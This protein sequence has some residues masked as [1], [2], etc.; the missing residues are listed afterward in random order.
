MR[1]SILVVCMCLLGTALAQAATPPPVVSAPPPM[2]QSPA[3]SESAA[4][5]VECGLVPPDFRAPLR[6]FSPEYYA[7]QKPSCLADRMAFYKV[8]GVSMAIIDENRIAWARGYGRLEAGTDRMV[9]TRSVFEA[10]SATKILTTVVALRLAEKGVVDLDRDVNAYLRQWKVP[11]SPLTASQ[12]VTLRLLLTHRAGINRPA[13]GLPYDST[14]PAT[15]AQV[16]AG[17]APALN[18]GATI[19]HEPGTIHQYSNIGFLVIQAVL[20]DASGKPFEELARSLVFEPLGLGASTLTHPL[21]QDWENR[22]GVPHDENGT[23][24]RRQQM[25]GAVAHGGLVTSPSDLARLAIEIGLAC[26]GRSTRLLSKKSAAMMVAKVADIDPRQFG[27]PLGQGLGVMLLGEGKT[28]HFLHPGGNDPGANCWV[29][30]CPSTGQGAVIMTNA[31]AGE[32]LML[33][34]LASI[35]HQYHWSD[36]AA[37]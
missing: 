24:H 37:R 35:A 8:P 15:L 29:I 7:S 17:M 33:E 14:L 9:T 10:A 36:L 13:K 19:E 28:L 21:A 25:A 4:R 1:S 2:A 5:D 12:P 34:V 20:E 6:I 31:A 3:A 22:W 16:L 23:P 30:L 32:A 27:G 18:E 11:A 26:Q